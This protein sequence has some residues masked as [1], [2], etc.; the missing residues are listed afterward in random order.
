MADRR[1]EVQAPRAVQRELGPGAA[2]LLPVERRRP[3]VLLHRGP[4]VRQPQ[5]RTA[6]AAVLD[7]AEVLAG[8][9]R[10]SCEEERLEVHAMSRPLVVEREAV[11]GEADLDQAARMRHPGRRLRSLR[12]SVPERIDDGGLN[13]FRNESSGRRVRGTQRVRPQRVLD[14]G[15]D[16]LLVLLLVLEAQLDAVEGVA[17]VRRR[18]PSS[19]SIRSSMASR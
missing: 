12:S 11:P 9:H 2:A 19:A 15:E 10:L 3:A 13:S 4:A 18:Q 17:A 6:V 7:E 1:V 8:G 14:V 5:V 16:Q